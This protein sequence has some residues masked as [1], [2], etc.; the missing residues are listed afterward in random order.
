MRKIQVDVAQ[1]KDLIEIQK[2]T[3]RKAAQILGC[4][5]DTIFR[6]CRAFSLQTQRTGPRGGAGHPKW[7]G[8]TAY[9]KGYRYVWCPDH[10][11]ATKAHR[12]AEHRLVMEGIVGRYLLPQETVHHVDGD[13]LNNSPQNLVLFGSNAEHLRHELSGRV[14]K[15]TE[16]GLRRMKEGLARGH[17]ILEALAAERRAAAGDPMR[18]PKGRPSKAKACKLALAASGPKPKP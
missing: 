6:A 18:T 15:W 9:M 2:V 5:V 8:G 11:H 7:R 1:L 12:V 13:P 10:P 4:S 14:P 17:K 3:Q 16:D